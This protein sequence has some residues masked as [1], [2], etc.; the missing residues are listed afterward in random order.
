MT[1]LLENIFSYKASASIWC[2]RKPGST[3]GNPQA[4]TS[5]TLSE[6]Q[7]LSIS[8]FVCNLNISFVYISF[9]YMR[10]CLF[11]LYKPGIITLARRRSP[12]HNVCKHLLRNWNTPDRIGRIFLD[13][14]LK[15]AFLVESV[16]VCMP[17]IT[18]TVSI[19]ANGDRNGDYSLLDLN[20][21]TQKFE[22]SRM[23]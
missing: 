18:G 9:C 15:F 1:P 11:Y 23:G 7:L 3:V 21:V 6:H 16:S 20:P 13:I 17:G 10:S 8:T 22:V 5:P 12:E 2:E 14:Y 19:D 4:D